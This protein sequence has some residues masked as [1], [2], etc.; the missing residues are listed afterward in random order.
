M[1]ERNNLSWRAGRGDK[2]GDVRKTKQPHLRERR[3]FDLLVLKDQ[4]GKY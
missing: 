3:L 1:G 4:S 2:P